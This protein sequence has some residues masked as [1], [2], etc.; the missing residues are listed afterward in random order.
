MLVALACLAFT[1]SAHA[2]TGIT[3]EPGR[4]T[5]DQPLSPGLAYTLPT[6]AVRNHGTG[7]LRVTA[8]PSDHATEVAETPPASWFS[9]EPAD[10]LV[11]ASAVREVQIVAEVPADAPAGEYAVWFAFDAGPENSSGIA[12][13]ANVQVPF[14]F[15]VEHPSNTPWLLWG[16]AASGIAAVVIGGPRA[17]RALRR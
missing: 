15:S 16:I 17:L 3:V 7:D 6:Y 1:T 9:I 13:A 10:L 12:T 2:Q 8:A 4:V 5:A 14:Y 11:P